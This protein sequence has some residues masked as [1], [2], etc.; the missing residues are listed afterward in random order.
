MVIYIIACILE[1]HVTV[2][3]QYFRNKS[4]HSH[5]NTI[6]SLLDFVQYLYNDKYNASSMLYPTHVYTGR[7]IE[8][9]HLAQV[10]GTKSTSYIQICMCANLAPLM[11]KCIVYQLIPADNQALFPKKWSKSYTL[12]HSNT[13]AHAYGPFWSY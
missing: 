3:H 1:C 12:T 4:M 9:L 13:A 6:T 8:W 10:F 5:H 2:S 7:T 11:I